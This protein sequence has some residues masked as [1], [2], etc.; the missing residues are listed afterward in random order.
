MIKQGWKEK[1]V[2]VMG[3]IPIFFSSSICRVYA[4]DDE[5]SGG[6]GGDVSQEAAKGIFGGLYTTDLM[7]C[8]LLVAVFF[9]LLLV[10]VM[11]FCQRG[12]ARRGVVKQLQRQVGDLEAAQRAVPVHS[13]A[14][15]YPDYPNHQDRSD[16]IIQQGQQVIAGRNSYRGPETYHQPP[17]AAP[18]QRVQE[19]VRQSPLDIFLAEYNALSHQDLHGYNGKQA[20]TAFVQK[21]TIR[22]FACTNYDERMR[23]P[24]LQPLYADVSTPM[25]GP[26][27]A[28]RLPQQ[29][30]YVVVPNL[31]LNYEN[32]V[33]I[34]GGMKEAFLSNYQ[35][36]SYAHI[37]VIQAAD[38][39]YANGHWTILRP[40]RIRLS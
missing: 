17:S 14:P 21:Y 10:V 34:V 19:P 26:Y 20:R 36:G 31:T 40:G 30:N 3:M 11:L 15:A 35:Q 27:W 8:I 13:A 29:E 24:G 1:I 33:H 6:G 32:Q 16:A 7:V 23:Q 18:R 28:V 22:A 39:G 25:G 9:L 38:F 2:Y 4:A 37:E 12:F 5:G